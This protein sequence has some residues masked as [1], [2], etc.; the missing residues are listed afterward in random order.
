MSVSQTP[1]SK[2]RSER[3]PG[4]VDDGLG[5]WTAGRRNLTVGLVLT[6]TLVGFEALAVST[7]MP[8]V[9]RELRNLQLYGW[10]FTAFMLG[11]L[12]G[13]VVVGGIIDRRGL[14]MPF[15]VGIAL[16]AAGLVV[17]GL[18]PSMEV[19][20]GGR[21]LQGLGAGTVP[22]IAYVAIGRSLPERLRPQMFATL[23]TAW[24]LPGLLGPAIAGAI[25]ESIGWRWV[26]LGLLPLIAISSGIAYPQVRR[27]GPGA[28]SES[29]ATL[30]QRLPL[31][32]VVTAGTGLLLGGLTSGQPVLLV[33]LGTAG[34]VLAILGLR[35][36]TPP[37]TLVAARGLPAA[38]LVRGIITFAFFAVN[39]YIALALVEWRGLTATEAGISLTAATLTWTVGSWIQARLSSRFPPERFVQAG[40][41]VLI[42]GLGTFL[43]IL[44]PQFSPW[45]SIPTIGLAGLGMGLAYS[46]L[47]LIV[48]REAAGAEQGRASSALSLTDSLGTALGTGIT[49]AAV[50]A[51]VRDAGTPLRGLLVGFGVAIA[52]ALLGL[53]LSV[54]LPVATRP[55][56]PASPVPVA[57]R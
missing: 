50:A 45:W 5:L 8:I 56:T 20:V 25:G 37:G 28:P 52:V 3:P 9:A 32:L 15:A 16:F 24:V 29:A 13:I 22:P 26:F 55:S 19:L 27:V 39:A 44:F 43:V 41:A 35:R 11:S 30:R 2:G 33:G 54:R 57:G 6:V 34:A 23:S 7:V 48:L 1:E 21:F 31:A 17:G 47:A 49:G 53:V 42:A 4:P 51:S 36:L 10:V 18:A 12:V 46:P 40:I 14:G 38:V